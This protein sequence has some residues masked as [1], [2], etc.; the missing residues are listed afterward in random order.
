MTAMVKRTVGLLTEGGDCP[1]LNAAIRSVVKAS[2]LDFDCEVVGFLDGFRGLVEDRSRL[3]GYDD[4]SNVLTEGGTLLGSSNRDRLFALPGQTLEPADRTEEALRV[5]RRHGLAGLICTGGDGTLTV[6]HHLHERGLPI[7]GIPKTI[8]NDVVQTDQAIG[9]DTAFTLA[10]ESID[11][12]HSTAASHHRVLVVEVMGRNAG[13]IALHAGVAGGGDI[14]LIPE[15][16]YTLEMVGRVIEERTRKGRKSSLVVLAEGAGRAVDLAPRIEKTTGRECRA[17]VLG[18]LQ[19]GGSPTPFDR[20]L[21]SELGYAAAGLAARGQYGNMVAWRSGR[22][23]SV[24]LS[25]VAGRTRT[26]SPDCPLLAVARGVGTSFGDCLL[27]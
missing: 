5:F 25:E 13:W 21:A 17:V 4:V 24:P 15:I 7:I 1:G 9:F 6:A 22:V 10:T 20:L 2:K 3:L 27:R 23:A 19:R 11:R 16:P 14:L 26:I 18:Y 8:D 12:L